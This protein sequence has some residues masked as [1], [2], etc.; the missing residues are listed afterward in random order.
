MSEP[1]VQAL[2]PKFAVEVEGVDHAW[3]HDTITTEQLAALGGFDAS[4]GVIMV[5]AD[6]N[7]R[8]LAPG[9]VVTLKPGHRFG[10]RPR[11]RRG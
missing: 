11:F 5:D 2:G 7:E 1:P 9:E 3:N 10:K 8:T 6:G 4:L